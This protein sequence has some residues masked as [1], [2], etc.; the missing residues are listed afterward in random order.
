MELSHDEDKA[1]A[2][3]QHFDGIL[4][5]PGNRAAQLD[6]SILNLPSIGEQLLDHCFSEEEI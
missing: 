6:L 5:T 2:F 3:F 4:G 1:E